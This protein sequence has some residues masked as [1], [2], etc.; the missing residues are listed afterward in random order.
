MKKTQSRL[1]LVHGN[2]LIILDAEEQ[3]QGEVLV[4][5]SLFVK[6]KVKDLGTR[7]EVV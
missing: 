3:R 4:V 7:L 5:L 6:F 2:I 1:A